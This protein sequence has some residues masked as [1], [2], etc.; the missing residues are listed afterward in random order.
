MVNTDSSTILV[1]KGPPTRNKM[2]SNSIWGGKGDIYFGFGPPQKILLK[3]NKQIIANT[4]TGQADKSTASTPNEKGDS[5]NSRIKLAQKARLIG[6]LVTAVTP[7]NEQN[8]QICANWWGYT[9]SDNESEEGSARLHS[10]ANSET[11]TLP[12][13]SDCRV[14]VS[15]NLVFY[16]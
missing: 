14:I 12:N 11:F 1:G 2:R 7:N 10:N 6:K 4:D 15:F 13:P 16:E 9:C 3:D 5:K 8:K